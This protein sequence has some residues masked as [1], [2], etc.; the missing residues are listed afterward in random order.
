MTKL[1]DQTVPVSEHKRSWDA[2]KQ[3]LGVSRHDAINIQRQ[4]FRMGDQHNLGW[5]LG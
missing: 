1:I 2:T 3:I 5:N 4:D